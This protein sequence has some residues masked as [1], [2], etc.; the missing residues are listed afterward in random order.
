[1]ARILVADDDPFIPRILQDRL[2]AAGHDVAIA[3]DGEEA[4]ALIDGVDVLLLDLQMPKK[5]GFAV[6][7]A[8]RG[9][10]SA[11]TAIVV[12]AHGDVDKAVR[13]MKAGAYDFLAKPFEGEQVELVVARALERQRL[14]LDVDR[15][16][17]EIAGR[18]G[19]VRGPDPAMAKLAATVEKIA[20]TNA[21][22][23]L[24]G[25]TGTGK[26]VVARALHAHSPRCS[27]PFVA[28]NCA[29][30]SEQ[31][32]ESELF[33]H[34]K[35]SF[36]GASRSRAGKIEAADGG[37]LFLDE[38]GELAA[39]LQAKLLRVLQEREVERVGGDH[40]VK[41][42]VRIV[43]ATNRDLARAIAEGRF[44]DDLYYRLKVI[45]LALP[46]LRD[47]R[48]DVETLAVALV[49]RCAA[50]A[51]R[52]APRISLA[53][54]AALRA[55]AWPGNVR[56]LAN[57]MER[58][59]LLGGDPIELCDLPDEVTAT[60]LPQASASTFEDVL[61]LPY[62]EALTGAR[63]LIV[64]AALQRTDGH[65]TKAAELLGL[66]Q[67]YLSRLMKSLGIRS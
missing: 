36:T 66:T 54:L 26:E 8:L 42:D 1:M 6:L 40:P 25:E 62:A 34:V 43:A 57:V 31:L 56:E 30:L 41:V 39:P 33:G 59:V 63:R 10:P 21:T 38:I 53:A 23:L 44:R 29:V 18:H 58:C 3:K 4:L 13:A 15:M 51:G 11:P 49:A 67:P 47:R 5:D 12:T 55:Y 50:D 52:P 32:L 37:T 14:K 24:L 20:P 22:V 61:A 9:L 48:L 35:G 17:G 60:P 45:T 46:A 16:R 28:V 2:R 64:A 19:W 27:G 7:E 65:Q